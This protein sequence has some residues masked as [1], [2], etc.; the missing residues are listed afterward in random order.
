CSCCYVLP[1]QCVR[2]NLIGGSSVK[3]WCICSITSADSEAGPMVQMILVLLTGRVLLF[4][5]ADESTDTIS[6]L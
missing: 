3:A 2:V 5:F 4:P 1:G 6:N